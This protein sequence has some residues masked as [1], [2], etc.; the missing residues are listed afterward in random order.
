MFRVLVPDARGKCE[1][2]PEDSAK[3]LLPQ[4]ATAGNARKPVV[5]LGAAH[6]LE[7]RPGRA[8]ST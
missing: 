5:F 2:V 7:K 8:F 3:S 6:V 1:K 4:D